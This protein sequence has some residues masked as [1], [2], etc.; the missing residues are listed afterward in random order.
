MK[1]FINILLI[2]FVGGISGF[3]LSDVFMPKISEMPYFS[4]IGWLQNIKNK[5]VIVNKTEEVYVTESENIYKAMEKNK[6][7][8][9]FV[10]TFQGERLLSSGIGFIVSSDGLILTRT[11]VVPNKENNISVT[12][13]EQAFPAE[14]FK[15]SDEHSLVLLKSQASNFTPVS[16]I[17]GRG[18][19]LGNKVMLFGKKQVSG[20]AVDFVN[21]GI[22]KSAHNGI[23]ETNIVEEVGLASGTPLVNFSGE[24]VG[25]N[26]VNSKGN[27]ISVSSDTIKEFI[28]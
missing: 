5:T 21:I 20:E 15:K 18:S 3:L 16:F 24:I 27:V 26:F 1:Y 4:D 23:I 14:F 6:Q 9:V 8:I 19:L 22:V 12:I 13:G 17:N 11:E 2:L 25:I 7:S 10:R 28:Y